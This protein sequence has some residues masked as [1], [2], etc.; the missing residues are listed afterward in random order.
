MDLTDQGTL[1]AVVAF[2]AVALSIVAAAVG[3]ALWFGENG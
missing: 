3:Y 1:V 2:T